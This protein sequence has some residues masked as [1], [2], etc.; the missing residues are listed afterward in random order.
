MV[1]SSSEVRLYYTLRKKCF[2]DTSGRPKVKFLYKKTYRKILKNIKVV[3]A[4]IMAGK[5]SQRTP[6]CTTQNV[7]LDESTEFQSVINIIH[8]R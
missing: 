8:D 6:S 4:G 5:K 7:N 3:S 2:S 1:S